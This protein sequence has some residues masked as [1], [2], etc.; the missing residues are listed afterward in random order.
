V[1]AIAGHELRPDYMAVGLVPPSA[2]LQGLTNRLKITWGYARGERFNTPSPFRKVRLERELRRRKQQWEQL[3]SQAITDPKAFLLLYPMQLQPES[4]LDVWAQEFQDQVALLRT[5]HD[6]T[7]SDVQIL[8]KPNPKSYYEMSNELLALVRAGKRFVPIS[9]PRK[10]REMFGVCHAI[11]TINGTVAL[12][13]TFAGKPVSTLVPMMANR[14][15]GCAHFSDPKMIAD[16]IKNGRTNG[17]AT[18]SESEKEELLQG[19]VASSYPGVISNPFLMPAC[20][21]TRNLDDVV[22][23]FRRILALI[24]EEPKRALTKAFTEA[25][26]QLQPAELRVTT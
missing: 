20:L 5:L 21:D 22:S 15:N 18:S 24:T 11:V 1:A 4:S 10:M 7:P 26:R 9:H 19:L 25:P 2:P 13:A 3:A 17:F 23:A 12:E 6:C 14:A 16:W 8:V